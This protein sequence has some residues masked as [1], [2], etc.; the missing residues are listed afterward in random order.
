M[1]STFAFQ[2]EDEGSIPS[3]CSKAVGDKGSIPL[4][5]VYYMQSK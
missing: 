4:V 2:A 1:A 5:V 3:T